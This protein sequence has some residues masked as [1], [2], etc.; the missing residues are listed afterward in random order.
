MRGGERHRLDLVVGD[1]DDR[2]AGALVHA[3]D[4]GAHLHPE[5][6]VEVRQRLVE[7]E[8]LRIAHQGAA[9]RHALALS[10]RELGGLALEEVT[11][12][13]KLG[14]LADLPLALRLRHLAHLHAETDVLG[15]AHRRVERVGLEHHRDVTLARRHTGDVAPGD[16]EPPVTDLLEPG[17]AVQQRRLAAAGRADQ[18]EELPRR[19]RDV[20][21]RK[22]D[23][24]PEALVQVD[25]LERTLSDVS[26][27][28]SVASGRIPGRL[29]GCC[30]AHRCPGRRGTARRVVRR[31]RH[32]V[33]RPLARTC[34]VRQGT[35]VPRIA[36]RA[37]VP[38]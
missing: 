31:C 35:V 15:D 28:G 36:E 37:S 32:R 1:V 4:L 29:P 14:H 24:L 10:A 8:Q 5:L 3:L 9:H 25:D 30:P 20:D 21:A 13:Q 2:G 27:G 26:G 11:D 38:S 19:H 22:H 17:D 7:Q 16:L 18:H 33:H 23:G 12:L 6:R 34:P